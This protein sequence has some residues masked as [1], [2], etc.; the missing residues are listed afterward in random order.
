[1]VRRLRPSIVHPRA[2]VARFTVPP[3]QRMS[4]HRRIYGARIPAPRL[5]RAVL[6]ARRIFEI[7]KTLTQPAMERGSPCATCS[8]RFDVYLIDEVN[9][10]PGPALSPK[11][12]RGLQQRA[13]VAFR[14]YSR[15]R[16]TPRR[17]AVMANEVQSSRCAN[18]IDEMS[19]RAGAI[20]IASSRTS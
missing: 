1:V 5:C 20:T 15:E 2:L 14:Y 3:G 19:A 18:S 7:R 4:P 8:H 11:M 6:R 10:H 12:R 16:I 17:P 9:E 13:H